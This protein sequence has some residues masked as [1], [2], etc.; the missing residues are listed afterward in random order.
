[1]GIKTK[2]NPDGN[3]TFS[4]DVL[5]IEKCGPT[6][7]YLTVIDVPGIFRN[8]EEG[9]TTERDKTLVLDMV[10]GY[11]EQERTIILA[12]LPSTVDIMTQEILNLAEKYDKSGERTL[13]VLTKPDLLTE[14]ST[15]AVVCDL[16]NGK[17]RPLNLGYYVVRNR[18]ADEDSQDEMLSRRR[19]DMFKEEPW[20]NL[21]P[22][23]V[24][25]VALRERLQEL[26]GQITDRAF[27][28][29]RAE[30]RRML[31]ACKKSLDSLGFSRQTEREQQVYL[32][33]LAGQFQRLV[34][35]S[36]EANYSSHPTLDSDELRLI[37]DIVNITDKFNDN[38]ICAWHSHYFQ[39]VG[40]AP[41]SEDSSEY[42]VPAEADE[43]SN[44]EDSHHT[45]E[46]TADQFPEL[47]SIIDMDS[48]LEKPHGDIM[49]WIKNMYYRSRGLELT[50]GPELLASAF[51]EQSKKWEPLAKTY[52]SKVILTIHRFI[53]TILGE[54]CS[55]TKVL[56]E[57]KSVLSS[58]LLDR[59][60]AAMD[61]AMFLVNIERDTKPYTLHKSFSNALE[62]SS[63]RRVVHSLGGDG[64][65]VTH[66]GKRALLVSN[67]ED[68]L[69]TKSN[70]AKTTELIHDTLE[71]YYDVAKQ[72]F[73]DNVS[74]QAVHHGLLMGPKSPLFLF[75]EKW[76]L[77]LDD[78][79]LEAIAGE[80]RLVRD[81]RE[82]LKKK[83]HDLE[84]A[85]EILR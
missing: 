45:V 36:L 4:Q 35:Y 27:P 54:I 48:I 44:G 50:F 80:S 69:K 9:V 53:V 47:D 8:T 52:M 19:E 66:H 10:K 28:K 73:V 49:D 15:K 60:Q 75:S 63:T 57:L 17:K 78:K 65:Y 83:I 62:E 70:T 84:T 79:K 41:I 29:L 7:D 82:Q 14:R 42:E 38:F 33:D 1:M 31:T 20:C 30:A 76:V 72:R 26:L 16:V 68:A 59:Y 55:D 18:G 61:Q 34:R 37:T 43:E 11:I 25:V 6:E 40:E 64:A 24:G 56:E 71:A 13:G 67:I 21:P 58:D 77:E 12:V 5:K 85:V 2:M 23:R 51:R 74:R 81:K 39:G 46:L 32:S 22:D 3:K